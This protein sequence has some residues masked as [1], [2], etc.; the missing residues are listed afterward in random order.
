MKI[1]IL[2]YAPLFGRMEE[3]LDQI[4]R[5]CLA[6]PSDL[7]VLPELCATGY[8]FRDRDELSALSQRKDGPFLARLIS[9]AAQHGHHLALGFPEKDGE[10]LYNSAALIGP[11]GLVGLYR[12]V[13]LFATEKR[14]FDPGNLGF[15]V[16][17]IPGARVGMMICFDWL[18]PESAR[19][20]SLRGA[21]IIAHPS[22]LVLPHCQQA[23]ITRALE[24][25]VFT[26]TA[27]RLGV[28]T[29]IPGQSYRFTGQSRIVGP[30]GR[31]L[32]DG[33]PD[34]PEVLTVEI[35]P[36]QAQDKAFTPRNDIFQDRRTNQYRLGKKSAR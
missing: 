27:N 15:G 13:H 3:N 12:K 2:Q 5:S 24:N 9:F 36:R 28:E 10:R 33:S 31:V 18:F 21:E 6:H 11:G 8:Q 35:D 25:R 34:Q 17:Q 32:A 22:N 7:F 4:E 14:L 29:R 30:D 19:M 1:S 20:L 26:V 23:M 16:F